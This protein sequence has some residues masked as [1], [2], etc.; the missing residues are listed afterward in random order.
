MPKQSF[1]T[2]DVDMMAH[3]IHQSGLKK[4][5]DRK[6]S[7]K[8][9]KN[10]YTFFNDCFTRETKLSDTIEMFADV[11]ID[12]WTFEDLFISLN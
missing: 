2:E 11:N 8:C 1:M 4:S 10:D 6:M 3:F 5:D 9:Q 7:V 12:S